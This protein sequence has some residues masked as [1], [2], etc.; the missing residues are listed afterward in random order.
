MGANLWHYCYDDFLT[1]KC[2][3]SIR[4]RHCYDITLCRFG[5]LLAKQYIRPLSTGP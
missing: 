4:Q 3:E 2:H 1:N 5:K